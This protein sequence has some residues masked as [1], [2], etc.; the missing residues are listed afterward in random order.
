MSNLKH[1]DAGPKASSLIK[2]LRSIGYTFNDAIS[3]LI[4][5]SISAK[6]TLI[7]IEFGWEDSKPYMSMEDNGCGMNLDELIQAMTI[8]GKSPTDE[9]DPMDLGR[10]GLGLKTASFSQTDTRSRV[11]E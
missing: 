8:G 2:S 1:I 7:N 6:A 9:R 4:D 11:M 10:F 5:N 3:D